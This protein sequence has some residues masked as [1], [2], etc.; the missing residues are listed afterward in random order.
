MRGVWLLSIIFAFLLMS[1]TSLAEEVF[2]GAPLEPPAGRVI[3]GWGQFSSEWDLGQAAGKTETEELAAYEKAVAPHTP[4]MIV[5]DVGPDF[6]IVSGFMNHYREFAAGHGFFVGQVGINFRGLEHDVSIGMRDPDLMVLADAL[7]HIGRPTLVVTGAKFNATGT[8]YEPSAYIGSFRHA[9]DIMR[10]AHMNC[11]MVWEAAAQG[12]SNSQP[13]KWYP[14]DDVVDWWGI[15]LAEARDFNSLEAKAL[16]DE[17]A[18][19]RKPVLIDAPAPSGRSE[20]EALNWYSAF[21]DFIRANP[22]IK[23]LSLRWPAKR[24]NRWPKVAAYVKQQLADPRYI[25][26]T[27]APGIFR[28][29]RDQQ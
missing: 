21:F 29:P 28:P 11:A 3:S 18:H 6:T 7:H 20:T 17:A 8:P 25:D 19:H 1:G 2:F 9:T 15:D 23:A 24:M 16:V 10:K 22:A 14:G 12:L 26:A 4:A 27:E 5:F 13:M